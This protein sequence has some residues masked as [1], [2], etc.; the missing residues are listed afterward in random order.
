[1]PNRTKKNLHAYEMAP[2]GPRAC[3]VADYVRLIYQAKIM[4]IAK[5]NI[6]FKHFCGNRASALL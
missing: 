1:M 5:R 4:K 3:T 2:N 6:E